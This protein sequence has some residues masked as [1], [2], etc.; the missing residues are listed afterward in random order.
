MHEFDL[1]IRGGDLIDGTGGPRFR[2]DVAVLDGAIAQVGEVSG[3]GRREIDAAGRLVHPGFVDI[4]THYD[5][6][7]TWDATLAP[8]SWHGVT[9]VVMGNCGVGF[10][11]VRPSDH[12]RLIQL[13]EGVEDIPG[14]A[15]DEGLPWAWESF[16]EYLDFLDSVPH[17]IDLGAQ[18]PH[19]A[20][21]LHVMGERGAAREKATEEDIRAMGEIA[22]RAM[23]AGAIGFTSSRTML[24]KSSLG[25]PTPSLDASFD[26]VVGIAQAIGA[27]GK[28]VLQM[29]SDFDD[30]RAEFHM[31]VEMARRSGRPISI[32]VAQFDAG[33][34]WRNLLDDMERAS[35]EQGV[36]M[37]GQVAARPVG[38]MM[39]HFGT[40]SPF[41]ACPSYQQVKR[42]PRG[43]WVARLR[44]PQ[45][46]AAILREA[47]AGAGQGDGELSL[48]NSAQQQRWEAIFP[49]SDPPCY[50]PPPQ[51]S[52]AAQAQAAG[53]PPQ[54][55]AYDLMLRDE[56]AAMLYLPFA[57]YVD[58]NLEAVREQLLHAASVPGLSDGGAHV[59][60]ICDASFPT[61]LLQWWGRDRPQ[62][63]IPLE[64]LVHKQCRAT[65]EAVGL[66]DRGLLAP[67]Y[68]ADINVTD[69]DALRLHS[70]KIVHDLPAGGK[71]F[72][73]K[74]DGI[75]H[76]FVSGVE[77]ASNSESLGATPGSL[78]R[79]AQPAPAV[80]A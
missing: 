30:Y 65:A 36:T 50:E 58:G 66:L 59:G 62:G 32:S 44:D 5:G 60:T 3:R 28:G 41:M 80:A 29:I 73:Q 39:G 70:P 79:G 48:L 6:Q 9:T 53:V 64:T 25:E 7:A 26:E 23:R 13:M 10:A 51:T 34:L 67:G 17:D 4:H 35:Q 68:K 15:L 75:D 27:T 71:R 46:R 77:V 63:R 24:H 43:Q 69:L 1:V 16:E 45:V 57:N 49:L 18:L 54:E 40:L 74:V 20:V 19:G 52:L 37:R 47:G 12:E 22:A 55:L 21:R 78:L 56:G 2:G 8:S 38:V 14:A 42:L 72:L 11:P 33:P 76:T 31:A 61:T